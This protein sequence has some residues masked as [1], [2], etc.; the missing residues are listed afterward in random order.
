MPEVRERFGRRRGEGER[1][2]LLDGC[3][4]LRSRALR[5]SHRPGTAMAIA[6]AK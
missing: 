5:C 6:T 2:E 4:R 1:L 3:C